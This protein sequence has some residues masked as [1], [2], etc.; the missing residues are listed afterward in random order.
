MATWTSHPVDE[1][2]ARGAFCKILSGAGGSDPY[3]LTITAASSSGKTF[4]VD[5]DQSSAFTDA[6]QFVVG[7]GEDGAAAGNIGLYTCDGNSSYS[8]GADETTITVIESIAANETDGRIWLES[9]GYPQIAY[10]IFDPSDSSGKLKF[11]SATSKTP[12]DSDDWEFSVLDELPASIS[13]SDVNAG[14]SAFYL[15]GDYTEYFANGSKFSVFQGV[16]PGGYICGGAIYNAETGSTKITATLVTG[17][18]LS[19]IAADT[20]ANSFKVSGNYATSFGGSAGGVNFVVRGST[21]ND[22]FYQSTSASYNSTTDRTTIIVNDVPDTTDDGKIST[23]TIPGTEFPVIGGA[24]FT[25]VDAD[26]EANSFKI[27]GN[28]VDTF[29]GTSGGVGFEV[30]ESADNNGLYVSLNA[31]YNSSEGRTVVFVSSVSSNTPGGTILVGEDSTKLTVAGNQTGTFVPDSEFFIAG[32]TGND[33]EYSTISATWDSQNGVTIIEVAGLPHPTHDGSIFLAAD[34][35]G[36]A[37]SLG[38]TGYDISAVKC[39]GIPQIAYRTMRHSF[40]NYMISNSPVPSADYGTQKYSIDDSGPVAS[41]LSLGL[42]EG[43]PAIAHFSEPDL[44]LL[45]SYADGVLPSSSDNWTQVEIAAGIP[46]SVRGF[47]PILRD[48]PLPSIFSAGSGRLWQHESL[49]GSPDTEDF[50]L[51]STTKGAAIIPS[52]FAPGSGRHASVVDNAPVAVFKDLRSNSP[53][54][55]TRL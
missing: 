35:T 28:A 47:T 29:G 19:I 53:E 14:E 27:D 38:G 9:S 12:T 8:G 4:K 11:A 22:G 3:P 34:A 10:F 26:S 20:D 51:A 39:N 13:I 50:N 37:I 36:V 17:S 31:S 54:S 43:L 49:S 46:S 5:G 18:Q 30:K 15:S 25:I 16:Y 33:G 45:Y 24:E 21:G 40:L 44:R 6:V 55:A 32:S 41:A 48:F 23:S 2:G 42:V 1:I 7:S 52:A